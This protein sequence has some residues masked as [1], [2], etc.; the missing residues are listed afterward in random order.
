MVWFPA[1]NPAML[2]LGFGSVERRVGMWMDAKMAYVHGWRG[3]KCR[4]DE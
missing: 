2:F 1:L 3:G 4:N